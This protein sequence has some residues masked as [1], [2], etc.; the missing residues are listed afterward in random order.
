MMTTDFGEFRKQVM[1][2]SKSRK[3][4]INNCLTTET[5]YYDLKRK[6]MIDK[7]LKRGE[8]RLIIRQFN[9]LLAE[10]LTKGNDIQFPHKM[11]RVEL[12]K[13]VP[14]VKFKNGKLY[15]GMPIDWNATLKLWQEDEECMK[16][17]QLVRKMEKE[18]FKIIYNKN[19]ADYNNRTFYD[20]RVCRDLKQALKTKI[21]NREID[22]FKFRRDD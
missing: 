19:K 11:G 17:K 4:K 20:F 15:N 22:A 1:K 10:E 7:H 6:G 21:Q 9:L 3:Q 18:M 16:N 14:T 8:F 13:L 5:I 12:R 2:V